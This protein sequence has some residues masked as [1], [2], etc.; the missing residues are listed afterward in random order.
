MFGRLPKEPITV[1]YLGTEYTQP[2]LEA[3]RTLM[4]QRVSISAVRL[5]TG[6]EGRSARHGFLITTE[7]DELIAIRPGFSS[8]YIGEGPRGLASALQIFDAFGFAVEEHRV[9][10]PLLTRIDGARLTEHD[11][12]RIEASVPV[13]PTRLHDYIYDAGAYHRPLNATLREFEPTIPFGIIDG[14]LADL[15]IGFFEDPNS[16]LMSG[17]ARLEGIIKKRTGLRGAASKL[18]SSA[19]EGT[20]AR[21]TWLGIDPSEQ[22][23]RSALFRSVYQTYRNRRVHNEAPSDEAMDLAEL[24]LL[25]NL[26]ILESSAVV[27]PECGHGN[28]Q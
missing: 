7:L 12:A 20:A 17:Y 23:G 2:C 4:Q 21:L 5:L 8:G 27:N 28:S 22:I 15:A 24:L 25:N 13:M 9:P 3:V 26:F 10:L 6:L 1:Q 14:R 19:F 11:L 16:R 18:F